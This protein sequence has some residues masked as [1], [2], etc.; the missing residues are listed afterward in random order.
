MHHRCFH[1][2][3]VVVVL[4]QRLYFF[5][6]GQ[7]Q[8][9]HGGL[10]LFLGKTIVQHRGRLFHVLQFI[11]QRVQHHGVFLH[12]ILT[13]GRKQRCCR[14]GGSSVEGGR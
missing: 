1:D 7:F 4:F 3:L 12:P 13:N 14:G 5:H 9:E 11:G 10:L 6:R 2:L 8:F